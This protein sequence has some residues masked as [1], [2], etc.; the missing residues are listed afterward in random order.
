MEANDMQVGGKHYHQ[1]EYQHWDFAIDTNMPHI[2][3]AATKYV[4][5]WRDKNG[6]QDLRKAAHYIAK[7]EEREVYMPKFDK[8]LSVNFMLQLGHEESAIISL[9]CEN[10]FAEAQRL[11]SELVINNQPRIDV[12]V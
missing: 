4:S 5:R 6:V 7:A 12:T 8:A 9:I 10:R 2:L 3:Y 1:H 11:I